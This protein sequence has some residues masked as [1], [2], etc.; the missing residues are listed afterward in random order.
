MFSIRSAVAR[1]MNAFSVELGKVR[2]QPEK[3][4]DLSESNPTRAGV[5]YDAERILQALSDPRALTY[6]PEPRGLLSA[7]QAI[8]EEW[9]RAS[10][11]VPAERILLTASTSEA[12]GLLFK[13]LCDPGDEV[14]VP[15]PSYPLFEH[16]ARFENVRPVPYGLGFDGGWFIDFE[17]LRAARTARTRA[18]IV[19]SPNNPTGNYVRR[20]ELAQ[21]AA[22][23]LPLISDEVFASYALRGP[24]AAARSALETDG[25]L[26]FALSGLSKLAGLPQMKAAW[27][28]IGG[29]ESAVAEAVARLE[30]IADAYLSIGAPVQLALPELLRARTLTEQHILARLRRNLA[31]LERS[32]KDAPLSVLPVEGGWY[33]VLRLPRTQSEEAWALGLL[34]EQRVLAQP[35]YFYDFAD[36]PFLV[37][38]LLSDEAEFELGVER[39]A[40]YVRRQCQ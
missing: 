17:R 33:A 9:Q 10:V 13:L 36:E 1:E 30:L 4:L 31:V 5:P 25:T 12:Y 2:A 6:E 38:S 35:G 20:A 28:G 19:V 14:L 39:L 37:L 8:S 26:V 22:L 11:N 7:R 29:P 23:G 27:L 34:R 3:L 40:S 24:E 32:L 21:L 15:A 18:I 16:L